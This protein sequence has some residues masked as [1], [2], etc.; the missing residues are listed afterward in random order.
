MAMQI[1]CPVLPYNEGAHTLAGYVSFLEPM[2]FVPVSV[3]QPLTFKDILVQLDFL[4]V[5]RRQGIKNINF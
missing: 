5:K 2:G 1:E 4:F 3:L